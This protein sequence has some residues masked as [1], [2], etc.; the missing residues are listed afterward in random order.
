VIALIDSGICNLASVAN[1]LGRVGA[2][3]D[4][5]AEPGRLR[6]AM[7]I[8]LP[9]VGAFADGMKSLRERGFVEPLRDAA[10]A[11]K[12]ILG[13]CLGMQLLV[14]ESE[15]H[16][17]H[18]GLGLLPGRVRRM[19]ADRPGFRVPNIGWCDVAVENPGTLYPKAGPAGAFYFV[20]S[21]SVDT[22]PR[23]VAA[24]IDF[25]GRRLV[26]AVE[27][28]SLSGVQFH[29]EKSQ[30][31]GLDLLARWVGHLQGTRR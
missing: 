10:K 21:Y 8:V 7:A 29:P 12:P 16:G 9:G 27:R 3:V 26:A 19:T 30:D 13:I 31:C 23:N 4:I 5:A 22:D 18:E 11:G 1:A 17:R 14:E 6:G 25:S 28:G 24:T 20:H 2:R 15:E